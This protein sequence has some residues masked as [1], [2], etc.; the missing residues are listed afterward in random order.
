MQTVINHSDIYKSNERTELLIT[1]SDK[2]VVDKTANN[3]LSTTLP[4]KRT[5]LPFEQNSG[6]ARLGFDRLPITL[7]IPCNYIL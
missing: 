1:Q 5:V 3:Q 6:P 4:G 7:Y 2:S